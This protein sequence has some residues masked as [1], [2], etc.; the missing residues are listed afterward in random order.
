VTWA[1]Q[2]P[3]YEPRHSR[4]HGKV[5]KVP[6]PQQVVKEDSRHHGGEDKHK[7]Q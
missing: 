5:K 6:A 1:H 3:V 7:L 2:R 4:Y